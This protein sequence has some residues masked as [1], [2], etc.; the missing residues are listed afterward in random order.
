[1]R[2]TKDK[3]SEQWGDISISGAGAD[4]P[5]DQH[6]LDLAK[7]DADPAV[8]KVRKYKG[9]HLKRSNHAFLINIH[10][11][12]KTIDQSWADHAFTDFVS[13]ERYIDTELLKQERNSK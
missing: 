3:F 6:E 10:S 11:D 5:D 12:E 2:K 8:T 7:Q 13:A 4:T 1:M 9:Y